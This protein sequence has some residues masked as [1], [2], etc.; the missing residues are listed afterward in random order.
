MA[1]SSTI[2]VINTNCCCR[3]LNANHAISA[4]EPHA[5]ARL[6]AAGHTSPSLAPVLSLAEPAA[7]LTPP[8]HSP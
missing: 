4:I 3:S 2:D 8:L 1:V 5:C 6:R 7:T